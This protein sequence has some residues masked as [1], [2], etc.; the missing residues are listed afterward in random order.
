MDHLTPKR[1]TVREDGEANSFAVLDDA[2]GRWWLSLL[3]NGEALTEL[4]RHNM[5]RLAACW[6]ACEGVATEELESKPGALQ[7]WRN[8]AG[9]R[10]AV[11]ALKAADYERLMQ[12]TAA[13]S[14]NERERASIAAALEIMNGIRAETGEAFPDDATHEIGTAGGTLEELD[15]DELRALRDRMQAGPVLVS[16]A[17]ADV[18]A[19]VVVN[20]D[21]GTVVDVRANVPARVLV[22]DANTDGAGFGAAEIEGARRLVYDYPI[23]AETAAANA[24]GLAD[25]ARAADSV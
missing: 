7:F 1:I 10:E 23:S 15:A 3:H 16:E 5:R 13:A 6:N 4:Q 22:L 17:P 8:E 20:L 14:L 19:L 25:V 2:R 24:A 21:G 12:S 18:G 9:N 11:F